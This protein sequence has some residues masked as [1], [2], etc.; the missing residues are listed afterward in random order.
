MNSFLDPFSPYYQ[1][2][3]F[4]SRFSQFIFSQDYFDKY[5]ASFAILM[6]GLSIWKNFQETETAIKIP[7][8]EFNKIPGTLRKQK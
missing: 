4:P 2:C 7:K 1:W 5:C 3:R 6:N 8:Q